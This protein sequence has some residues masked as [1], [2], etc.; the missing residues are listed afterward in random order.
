VLFNC[1]RRFE[2]GKGLRRVSSRWA[3]T[4]LTSPIRQY[5]LELHQSLRALCPPGHLREL[6]LEVHDPSIREV[7]GVRLAPPPLRRRTA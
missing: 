1:D 3:G 2:M 7:D 6:P 5:G 4:H